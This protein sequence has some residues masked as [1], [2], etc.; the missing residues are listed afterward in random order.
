[1]RPILTILAF[2]VITGCAPPSQVAPLISPV[3]TITVH[4]LQSSDMKI[5]LLAGSAE[6]KLGSVSAKSSMT[7]RIPSVLPTPSDLSLRAVPLVSGETQ[8]T[9]RV[10]LWPNSD[11]VFTIGQGAATSALLRKR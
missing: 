7:F 9:E 4:N 8:S 6:H 1:M 10:T 11:L 2:T 5:Y 3:S